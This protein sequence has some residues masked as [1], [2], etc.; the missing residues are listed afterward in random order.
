[1]SAV[2][3]GIEAGDLWQVGLGGG[4]RTDA[5]EVVRLV[6]G[7]QR[8]EPVELASTS[9]SIRTGAANS[10]PPCTTRWPTPASLASLSCSR[11]HPPSTRKK[12]A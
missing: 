6:Q 8:A 2:E 12:A 9:S 7:R 4:D 3:G 5:G 11:S 10:V 1:M